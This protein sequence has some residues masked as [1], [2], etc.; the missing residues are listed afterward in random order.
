MKKTVLTRNLTRYLPLI[1][2]TIIILV[3]S[4]I[5]LMPYVYYS[6]Y[7][8]WLQYDDTMYVW[9][10]TKVLAKNGLGYFYELGPQAT[11]DLWYWPTG[12]DVPGT[13]YPGLPFTSTILYYLLS[14]FGFKTY[15]AT[16]FTPALYGILSTLAASLVGYVVGGLPGATIF[17]AS[18][19]LQRAFLERT[20]ASFAEKVGP[21]VFFSLLAIL[22]LL[23][24]R[25]GDRKE[26]LIRGLIAGL[27]FGLSFTFWT[28]ALFFILAL[29]LFVM[30]Y[31]YFYEADWRRWTVLTLTSIPTALLIMLLAPVLWAR[32]PIFYVSAMVLIALISIVGS[33]LSK[34]NKNLWLTIVIA[35]I[36]GTLVLTIPL[37]KPLKKTFNPR[38]VIMLFPWLRKFAGPLQRSVAE[39]QGIFNTLPPS[40]I[41]EVIGVGILAPFSLIV[42]LRRKTELLSYMAL[43]GT[44]GFYLLV[45]NTS[46]Y[47][48]PLVGATTALGASSFILYLLEYYKRARFKEIPLIVLA[49]IMILLLLQIWNAVSYA[50]SYR[51]PTYLS[52]GIGLLTKAFP[53]SMNFLKNSDCQVVVAWWDYGYMIGAT[54]N[55][56]TIVDPST[57]LLGRIKLVGSILTSTPSQAAKLLVDK[58]HVPVGKTCIFTYDVYQV[59]RTKNGSSLFYIPLAGDTLKSIWMMRIA[60]LKDSQIWG[61]KLLVYVQGFTIMNTPFGARQVPMAVFTT[62]GG[63]KQTPQGIVVRTLDN[64]LVVFTQIQVSAVVPNLKDPG[65]I[66]LMLIGAASTKYKVIVPQPGPEGKVVFKEFTHVNI[67]HFKLIKAV[68]DNPRDPFTGRKFTNLA[69]VVA[70][71]KFVG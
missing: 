34:R 28:G 36:V 64:K 32:I 7:G 10:L 70:I 42:L 15:D 47:M 33:F 9:W 60:G 44:L 26:Y 65:L 49:I 63:I 8:V 54:A 21:A 19:G 61:K 66:Y 67:P 51:P 29:L 62:L 48:L 43:L 38:Y 18:I 31:P 16:G 57:K 2:L 71:Y 11:K 17:A 27:L 12:R 35:I 1:L 55:K 6:K 25:R 23:T 24:R 4:I 13:T 20:I 45:A 52:A 58:L 3:A 22:I 40:S 69:V 41:I 53:E 56:A 68:V 37:E 39:N 30:L 59:V 46:V 50:A 5:R 14:P